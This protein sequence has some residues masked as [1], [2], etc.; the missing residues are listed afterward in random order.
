[1]C[2]T[3]LLSGEDVALSDAARDERFR[4][5]PWVDGRL[6]TVGFYTSLILRTPDGQSDRHAVRVRQCSRVRCAT[7][8]SDRCSIVARQ[9]IEVLE[10]RARSRA[11]ERAMDELGRSH[12]KLAAF[13]GQVSHDLKSPLTSIIGFAELLQE[14]PSVAADASAIALRAAVPRLRRPD[15]RHH[16]PPARLRA[17]R[18]PARDRVRPARPR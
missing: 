13:A 17:R 8:T 6:G 18:R 3:T 1:M 4:A 16:R 2:Y 7:R 14:M 5:N 12:D 9:V 11:L 10:L 15:A